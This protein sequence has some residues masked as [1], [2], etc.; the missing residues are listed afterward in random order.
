MNC[1]KCGKEHDGSFGSGIFCCR[2]CANSRIF[3]EETKLL[4]SFSAKNSEKVKMGNKNRI[5]K[6]KPKIYNS[7]KECNRQFEI[8]SSMSPDRV[9]CSKECWLKNAGGYRAKSGRSKSGYYEGI[10]C[11]STYELIWVLYQIEHNIEFKRFEEMLVYDDYKYIPDFIQNNKIIEIKG[12]FSNNTLKQKYVAE[13]CGYTIKIL[14]KKDL[15]KEFK[16]FKEKY[17]NIKP[18]TLY[19]EYKPKYYYI[20]CTCGKIFGCDVK[21]KTDIVYCC[22]ICAGKHKR[23]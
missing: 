17:G 13:Q 4:K 14:T 6:V 10:Y 23:L 12:Y 2:S 16:W 11:G 22:R 1:K 8:T 5:K 21:R 20:C 3:T 7:C 15:E 18:Y 19:D 9:Y